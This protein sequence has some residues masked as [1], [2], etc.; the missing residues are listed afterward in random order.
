MSVEEKSDIISFYESG[1]SSIKIGKRLG[2]NPNTII[3]RLKTWGV[4]R[5]TPEQNGQKHSIDETFF[6][7]IDCEAKAYFL[8]LLFADGYNGE[9]KY[10]YKVAI[11]LKSPDEQLLR[12]FRF[13]IRS[14]HRIRVDSRNQSNFVFY[15]KRLSERLTELGCYRA[16]SLTCTFPEYLNDELL[17]H[18]IRGYIDGDGWIYLNGKGVTIGAIGSNSFMDRL[19]SIIK[20]ECRV[21]TFF[22]P[23]PTTPQVK[24]VIVRGRDQVSTV[25]AWLYKDATI[26]LERKKRKSETIL[27]PTYPANKPNGSDCH[28]TILKESDIPQIQDLLK[29][30]RGLQEIA[31]LFKVEKTAIRSI[32]SGRTWHHL[33]GWNKRTNVA[34]G[35]PKGSGHGMSKLT[36]SD[37]LT[38][39]DLI[40]EGLCN[41]D[42][43]TQFLVSKDMISKIRCGKNW[44]HITGF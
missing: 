13:A 23:H 8:G 38:I 2:I 16:K 10:K 31:D 42:I 20:D 35:T 40:N 3:R 6:D 25:L 33:T 22:W 12:A 28:L 17:P 18:F 44:K 24:S 11:S 19:A 43:S 29:A 7:V 30:G 37:V 39:R 41:F 26:W 5:R 34:K 32:S 21:H 15:N 36:E 27:T 14:Q 4:N 9:A 1:E